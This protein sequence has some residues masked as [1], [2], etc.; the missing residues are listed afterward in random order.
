VYRA[1]DRELEEVVALKIVRKDLLGRPG[2]IERFKREVKI[3]R[4]VTHPNVARV[5]DLGE[6]AGERFLTMEFVDGPSLGSMIDAGGALPLERARQI[7]IDICAGLGA[8]HA[9]GVIHRDLKPDNVLV[10]KEGRIVIT[11]F[12]VA[13]SLVLPVGKVT[14]RGGIIGTPAYMAPEQISGSTPA[15]VRSDI[16]ALG[17]LLY[18]TVTGA[19][20]WP[21]H[22]SSADDVRKVVAPPDPRAMRAELSASFAAVILRCVAQL[23]QDRFA[24]ADEVARA[25]AAVPV[26]LSGPPASAL[27]GSALAEPG[28]TPPVLPAEAPRALS[29]PATSRERTIALLPLVNLGSSED[30]YLANGLT[31][32]IIDA[33]SSAPRL[34][35]R[36]RGMAMAARLERPSTRDAGQ[37]LDVQVVGEGSIARNGDSLRVALRLVSVEDGVQVWSASFVR[38]MT[39]LPALVD[40]V[41]RAVAKML[42]TD[43]RSLRVSQVSSQVAD[44]YLRARHAYHGFWRPDVESSIALFE[45]ALTVAPDAA[46]IVAGHALACLRHSFFTGTGVDVARAAALRAVAVAPH[47][48]EARLALA[49]VKLQDDDAVGAVWELRRALAAAPA[50]AEANGLLGRILLEADMI[51]EAIQRLTWAV[52]LEPEQ[53]LARRDLRRAYILSGRWGAAQALAAREP[54]GDEIGLWLGRARY[55]VWRRDHAAALDVLKDMPVDDDVPHVALARS[56]LALVLYG[57]SPHQNKSYLDFVERARAT[58]RRALFASQLEAEILAYQDN[59]EGALSAIERAAAAGLSDLAWLERCPLIVQYRHD[60]RLRALRARVM[61]R[62]AAVRAAAQGIVPMTKR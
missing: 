41:A 62:A 6:S 45:R 19:P 29:L 2:L 20:M 13:R 50:L 57:T 56:L 55:S 28:D 39:R 37:A 7:A 54:P 11:D 49:S 58:P 43:A 32:E 4:S 48:A 15:D 21:E 36:P 9:S 3:A 51:E 17:A 25:L 27:A 44:L 23:P 10:S 52:T 30:D 42:S 26:A 38:P 14:M 22:Q 53:F 61:E 8:A 31:D 46:E 34:H 12:G 24:S 59:D 60:P 40:E 18:E 33:L 47:L 35:V 5:Y 16:Y 1:F